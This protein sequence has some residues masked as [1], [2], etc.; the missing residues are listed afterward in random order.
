LVLEDCFSTKV[1][2]AL[3]HAPNLTGRFFDLSSGEAGEILQKFRNYGIRLAV[4]CLPGTARFS[5]MFGEMAAEEGRRG[6]FRVFESAE[7]A[8][9]WLK[10][11]AAVPVT[12]L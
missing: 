9:E 4:V 12:P 11:T 5:T 1:R 3:L 10:Q 8:R 6:Y 2:A 7:S